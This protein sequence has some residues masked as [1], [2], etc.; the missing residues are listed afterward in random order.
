MI[1][2]LLF[3]Y[4][5][6]IDTNGIH[7]AVVLKNS[8]QHFGVEIP[9][10]LF[11]QAYTF[12]ERS[13]ALQSLVRPTDNFLDVLRL[14][15]R[16]QFLFLEEQGFLTNPEAIEMIAAH[17]NEFAADT[18]SVTRITLEELA[19]TYPLVMVSN[20]YGNLHTV[21]QEFGILHLFQSVIESAVVGCRKPDPKIYQLG[22]D[23]LGFNAVE[24]MVVG[25]TFGKDIV[26]AKAIGCPSIWLKCQG[27]EEDP[28]KIRESGIL[29]DYTITDFAEIPA[30]LISENST[31]QNTP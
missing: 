16:Q 10:T 18:V 17:C 31:S 4:G 27:W 7:W 21:L 6:T 2:G 13:L 29:A 19:K 23:S 5:G 20:F 1:K 12:G 3:D 11:S 25:D 24:C 8:Y 15:V 14:K 26:P 22:V 30:L 28:E 9:D